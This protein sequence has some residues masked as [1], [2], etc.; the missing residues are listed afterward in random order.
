MKYSE[1]RRAPRVNLAD[2]VPLDYPFTIFIEATNKCNFK[3]KFCPE[4][5]PDYEDIAGGIS[6]LQPDDFDIITRNISDLTGNRPIKTINFYMMGEPFINPHL[7]DY[8]RSLKEKRLVEKLIV[9][10][11]GSLLNSGRYQ[12]IIDSGLDYLRVSIYGAN[13]PEQQLNSQSSIPLSKI[14]SN[15]LG[16]KKFRDSISASKPYIYVKMIDSLS[17]DLNAEFLDLFFGVGDETVVEPRMN[18]DSPDGHNL[19]G[20]EESDLLQTDYFRHKKKACPF[21]F[22]T[23]I[24]HSDLTVGVC[25]VDWSKAINIGNLRDNTL[26]HIWSGDLLRELQIKHLSG[27]KNEI[28]ACRSCSFLHTAPDNI[29]SISADVFEA[30]IQSQRSS[31]AS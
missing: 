7:T 6:A 22:Y 1:L 30:R 16:L 20:L 12:S 17:L 24:I 18:W 3:C 25:C 10:S 14:R 8:L 28:E 11:N 15:I 23:L 31:P 9:T 21:P 13:D 19:S 27:R 5:F 4:S 26:R 2:A 29:D